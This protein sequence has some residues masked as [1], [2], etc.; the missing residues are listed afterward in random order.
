MRLDFESGGRRPWPMKLMLGVIRRYI[1]TLPGPQLVLSWRPD[2]LHS[3]MPRYIMRGVHDSGP[4]SKGE[5]E[6][7]AAFISDLNSCHF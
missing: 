1:G 7:F 3:R 2:L 4:W 5:A 6:M